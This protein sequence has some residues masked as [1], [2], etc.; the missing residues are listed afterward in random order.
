MR[1]INYEELKVGDKVVTRDG[2]EVRIYG[3][4][5]DS[6]RPIIVWFDE[7]ETEDY[8]GKEIQQYFSDGRRTASSNGFEDIFL[9]PK[10]EYVNL[11][12]DGE[13]FFRV[14]P[15]PYKARSDAETL[16]VYAEEK[17]WELVKT[18]EVEV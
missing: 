16:S 13:G 15:N 14:T 11:Y 10:K 9:P 18:I 1:E 4:E 3:L 5:P 7:D 2:R 12:R 17:G 6:I 8:R